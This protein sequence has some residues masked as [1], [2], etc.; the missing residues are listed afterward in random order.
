MED[1]KYMPAD[2]CEAKTQSESSAAPSSAS[3]EC[4]VLEGAARRHAR[5]ARAY[6]ALVMVA[7]AATLGAATYAWFTNNMKVNTNS[8]S[9]HSDTSKL[10]LELGDADR[11]SWSQQG[12][13]SLTSNATGAVTLYPVSTFDLNGFAACAQNNSA[14]DATVFEQA[15]DNGSAFYHGW[16]DL[17]PTIT[18]TGASKVRGKVN[19]YLA[20]SL[21]PQ[22][23]V[24]ELLRAARVG[25]KI[26]SG[27]QVLA[28]NIFELDS[29]DGGH[30]DE[31]PTTAP[32]GLAGYADGMLLGWR[33]G[34]LA[35]G[36]NVT[37]DP[38]AFTLDTSE[39]AK[40]RL[41]RWRWARPIVW[42]SITTSR[43]PTQ[44]APTISIKIRVPCTWR[45]LRPWMVR[46]NGTHH[47]RRPSAHRQRRPDTS[48]RAHRHRPA[49]QA[50]HHCGSGAVCA[51]GDSHGNV[52]LVLHR[53]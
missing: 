47:A 49:P 46:R 50:L 38:A 4:Q 21:V 32:A 3:A 11:G 28:T 24:A 36:T 19:L 13:V 34:Q 33:N 7:L 2:S 10:V 51:G 22:G 18:G 53:R 8:V 26:S 29:S 48:P 42:I 35:C 45:S 5:R 1:Q 14:G 39:T 9:V 41:P 23:A 37:Q 44:I 30:R 40:T 43:A 6:I 17:R 52:R 12:D 25:I 20:E 15:K 27:S 31:H 16:I